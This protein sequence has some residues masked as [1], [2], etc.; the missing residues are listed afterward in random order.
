MTDTIEER[1]EAWKEMDC[2]EE[3]FGTDSSTDALSVSVCV[4]VYARALVACVFM[5]TRK[6]VTNIFHDV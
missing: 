6:Y 2:G 4:C 3:S 1:M 5:Y